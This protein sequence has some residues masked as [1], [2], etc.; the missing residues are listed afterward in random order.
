[1]SDEI[2]KQVRQR[3]A[4][5]ACTPEKGQKWPFGPKSAKSLGYDK[6]EIDQLPRALT[7]SF[8]G[9]GNPLALGD[10]HAGEVVLDMGSGAGMDSILAARRVG[11][12]GH[13]IGVDITPEMVQKAKRNAAVVAQTN[14][15]F[16]EGDLEALP[17]E[18]SSVDLVISNGVFNLS[19]D[20]PKV[21]AEVFRVL[22][23]GGRL[24]MADILLHAD[25]T[26]NEVATKG[27]WS[28]CIA[29]AIWERSLREMLH[30]AGFVH[31]EFHGWTGYRT[32]SCT[33]G[34]LVSAKKP[35]SA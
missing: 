20:K 9:V 1:M 16:R 13:V 8:A 15:E 21:L 7:E 4:T 3:F 11:P 17:I 28:D 32:S 24:Q 25:V 10:V 27:E 19:P 18:N 33:E 6:D 34:A 2:R 29:G 31:V 22:R 14:A 23:R 5:L 12:S 35:T 26:P 30:D